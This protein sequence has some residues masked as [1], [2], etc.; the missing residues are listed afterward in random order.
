MLFY[1]FFLLCSDCVDYV[2]KKINYGFEYVNF[3]LCVKYFFL[4]LY[5]II[6]FVV[7]LKVKI[8]ENVNI[9]KIIYLFIIFI[10]GIMIIILK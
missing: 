9:R 5:K 1:L 8:L 4:Y 6:W 7:L 10:L 2:L 3:K